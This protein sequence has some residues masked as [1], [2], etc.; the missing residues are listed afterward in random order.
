VILKQTTVKISITRRNLSIYIS[1]SHKKTQVSQKEFSFYGDVFVLVKDSLP[2]NINLQYCLKKI[3]NTIPAH[4]VYGLDSVFI[5]E[6]PEFKDRQINAFY[7]EGAIYISNHQDNDDDFIDDLVH[8][9]A[10]LV[11]DTYGAA[12]FQDQKLARELLGKRQRL[13]YLLKAEGFQVQPS[14]FTNTEYSYEFDMFLFK[15]VGYDMLSLLTAGLF[16]SPYSATSIAEYF[17]EGFEAYFLG[18]R[19]ELKNISPECYKKIVK[20]NEIE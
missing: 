12:I 8:E 20:L 10:H 11:E 15:E 1:E 3:E 13:F 19:A 6:F 5:G 18:D 4:L 7:R 17:A 14:D 16:I 2:E 9:I